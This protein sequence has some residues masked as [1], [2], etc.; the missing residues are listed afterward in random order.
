VQNS[1]GQTATGSITITITSSGV[2]Q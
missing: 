1:I 2:C